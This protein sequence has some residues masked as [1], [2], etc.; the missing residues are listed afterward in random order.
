MNIISSILKSI[1]SRTLLV[2]N[3]KTTGKTVCMLFFVTGMFFINQSPTLA[4]SKR[5]TISGYVREK[6]S[7]ELLMGVTAYLPKLKAGAITNTYGFYSISVPEDT[8]EIVF[9]Y[10]GFKPQTHRLYLNKDI[11][12]NIDLISELVLQEVVITRSC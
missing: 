8:L 11:E 7:S 5:Y 4:Q 10:V 1:Q 12:L 9:S 3:S 6:G 2:N